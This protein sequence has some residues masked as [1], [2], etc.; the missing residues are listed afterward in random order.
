MLAGFCRGG[1]RHIHTC[2]SS[3][4]TGLLGAPECLLRLDVSSIFRVVVG[5]AVWFFRKLVP[6]DDDVRSLRARAHSLAES[7]GHDYIG[8]EH[9][10]LAF[11]NLPSDHF[12]WSV[13]RA[14]EVDLDAFFADLESQARVSTGR[15]A[16]STLPLTPRL[17]NILRD[18]NRMA[19]LQSVSHVTPLH[20]LAAIA[21]ERWS[22]P[23]MLLA[24]AY[25]QCHSEIRYDRILADT[26]LHCLLIPESP[27][28]RDPK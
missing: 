16:P 22:L 28:P 24:T 3:K 7:F 15:I 8:V 25:R 27:S 9:V 10:F 23:A 26:L 5:Y 14:F 18:A 19:R 17:K 20:I 21:Q 4:T 11:R 2:D 13:L 12:V 6:D 1:I